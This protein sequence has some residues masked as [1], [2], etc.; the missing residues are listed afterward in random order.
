M[1]TIIG[2]FGC[3]QQVSSFLEHHI[4]EVTL[5]CMLCGLLRQPDMTHGCWSLWSRTIRSFTKLHEILKR[6]TAMLT[7]FA[8]TKTK[9]RRMAPAGLRYVNSY[10][11]TRLA[12]GAYDIYRLL[13]D[14]QPPWTGKEQCSSRRITRA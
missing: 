5:Q 8:F 10:F 2:I 6:A 7:S 11:D 3:P 1:V 14:S 9:T 4:K 13:I 12:A